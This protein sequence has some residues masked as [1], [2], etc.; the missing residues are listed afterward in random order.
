MSA[1]AQAGVGG[2]HGEAAVGDGGLRLVGARVAVVGDSRTKVLSSMLCQLRSQL[3]V[4]ERTLALASRLQED[5]RVRV[6]PALPSQISGEA[7]PG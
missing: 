7:R 6:P 5:V 2:V 4:H 3:A 1:H